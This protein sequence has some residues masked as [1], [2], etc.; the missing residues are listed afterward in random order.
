M[1]PELPSHVRGLRRW[2][3]GACA[4]HLAS[5]VA[6]VAIANDFS[7]PV[8]ASWAQG[9]PG[10]TDS[11]PAQHLF[12]V[13]VAWAAASF[14]LLSALAHLLVA[15][16]G[17]QHYR[18]G[19]IESGINRFRWLEYSL[20]SSLMIVLIAQ[21]TGIFDVAALLALVG[22]NTSMILFGWQMDAR[23]ADRR[24][25]GSGPAWS[26]FW[27]GCSAG[28]VPWIAIGVYLLGAP[29]VPGFV[30]GIY[31]SLFAFFN[32]FAAVMLL[33]YARIGPWRRVLVAE[34]TY[35]AL[36]LTAKVALT[37]QVAANTL[38]D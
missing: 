31:V 18:R 3:L 37:W 35:I 36:S 14:A 20:S 22:V 12:D 27:F 30:Y 1:M 15:T 26:P 10:T 8:N 23:N 6:V 29:Q 4:L 9:P 28:I 17:W 21:L 7:L 34:R 33:E 25:M 32:V 38:L 5:G 24:Q 16:V 19:L 2:N 11:W 13:P